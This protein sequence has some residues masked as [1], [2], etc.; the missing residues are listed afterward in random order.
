MSSEPSLAHPLPAESCFATCLP[1]K[2][3]NTERSVKT[4][5]VEHA[6]ALVKTCPA[7]QTQ[8]VT[9][10]HTHLASCPEKEPSVGS[11]AACAAGRAKTGEL[12]ITSAPSADLCDV[13]CLWMCP[14]AEIGVHSGEE[15]KE[16]SHAQYTH[17]HSHTHSSVTRTSAPHLAAC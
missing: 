11:A 5:V 6:A 4:G 13:C 2:K 9:H 10:T 8:I 16:K 15:E 3:V 17:T 12:T 7:A 14:C 1:C